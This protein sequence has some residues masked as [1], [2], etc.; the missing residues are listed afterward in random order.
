[1]FSEGEPGEQSKYFTKAM[2]RLFEDLPV[3][4]VGRNVLGF[5]SL[6]SIV[7]LERA[8]GSKKTHQT[9]ME[10]IPHNP[11]VELPQNKIPT[12]LSLQWFAK[13]KFRICSVDVKLTADN[14]VFNVTNLKVDNFRLLLDSNTTAK[15]LKLLIDNKIGDKVN[16]I[17]IRGNQNRAVMEQLSD[18]TRNVQTLNFR[19]PENCMD[20]LTAE[21][22]SRWKLTEIHLYGLGITTTVVLLIVSTFPDLTRVYFTCKGIDDAAVIAIAEQ[23]P[24]LETLSIDSRI[25]TVASL[26][27]LS[28]RGLPLKELDVSYIPHIPTADIARRCS[29]ALSCI[30]HLD[31][32]NLY[33][34]GQD[35]NIL[36]PYMTG[37]TSVRLN[38]N[39]YIYI[40]LLTQYCH[41]LTEISM[42]ENSCTVAD[43][44]SLCH[45]N[46]QLQALHHHSGGFTDTA[47]IELTHACPHIHTLYLSSETDI[48]DTG[49]LALSKHCPQLQ[50]LTINR[51]H[52]VT[53]T[54]VLQL[55][56]CCRKLST[57]YVSR[58]S[59][60][61]E[62]WTQLDSNA[63]K[64]VRRW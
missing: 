56:Q 27:T 19:F 11:S 59:L 30:R 9:L 44:L 45:A 8:C 22:L 16:T 17:D 36:I 23:C 40:P 10:Q 58:G 18:C 2:F 48:T 24:K 46:S 26:L 50:L 4:L 15:N 3:D 53:E 28:E 34:N 31:T 63:Q 5:L 37:L 51:C 13:L 39:S 25:I 32:Y 42:A 49:I 6:K 29:H 60:S 43:I 62:T 35:A 61:E 38:Y 33:Q 55:L 12:L 57:L 14:P 54:A 47:L 20:W 21:I 52:Q 1:M 7:L 64:R 41:K